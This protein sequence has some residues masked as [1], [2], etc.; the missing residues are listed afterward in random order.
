MYDHTRLVQE[1]SLNTNLGILIL[2][3]YSNSV[4]E[5]TLLCY[6]FVK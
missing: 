6:S 5:R 1:Q 2:T 3:G 4:T